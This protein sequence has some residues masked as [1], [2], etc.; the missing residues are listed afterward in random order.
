MSFRCANIYTFI[1]MTAHSFRNIPTIQE[2]LC[3]GSALESDANLL[4]LTLFRFSDNFTLASLNMGNREC[5][6]SATFSSCLIRESDSKKSTIR[7]LVTDLQAGESQKYVCEASSLKPGERIKVA[8]WSLTI[9]G[10]RMYI[11][12]F[13]YTQKVS[14]V[15]HQRKLQNDRWRCLTDECLLCPFV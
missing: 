14:I 9:T 7:A 4:S 6:T 11:F 13:I 8:Y 5:S 10:K 2:I 1:G 3:T 12:L 15:L